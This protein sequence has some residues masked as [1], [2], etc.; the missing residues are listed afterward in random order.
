MVGG[1]IV[2]SVGFMYSGLPADMVPCK[3]AVLYFRGQF[4]HKVTTVEPLNQG[5]IG[6]QDG[7]SF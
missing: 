3:E 6:T 5:H 7:T 1:V 2:A 4:T